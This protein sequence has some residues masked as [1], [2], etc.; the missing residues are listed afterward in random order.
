MALLRLF[1][2][3]R[4]LLVLLL[5]GPTALAQPAL[6]L[7][8]D[9]LTARPGDTVLVALRMSGFQQMLTAQGT[10][11]FDSTV[12]EVLEAVPGPLSG[13]SAANFGQMGRQ[14]L[15]FAWF[16]PAVSG[17][18]LPDS[19]VLFQVR[20]RVVGTDGQRSPLRLTDAPTVVEF[21]RVGF[22]PVVPARGVGVVRVSALAATMPEVSD[23][24]FA[25]YPNPAPAEL[26]V[27]GAT[28]VWLTEPLTGRRHHLS[29]LPDGRLDLRRWPSGYYL[30]TPADQPARRPQ[31]LVLVR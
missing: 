5:G 21:T 31:P 11:A 8:L 22:Q 6:R 3:Y 18:S 9:S 23:A 14:Y 4:L 17:Q 29:I 26:M 27:R 13:L 7:K 25:F 1:T 24:G 12:I 19:T 20:F 2:R 30:L 16:D 15:T 10:L 28:A